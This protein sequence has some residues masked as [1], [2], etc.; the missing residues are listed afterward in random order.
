[1]TGH[2]IDPDREQFDYFKNL[3]RD[4]PIFMLNQVKFRAQACYP[5]DHQLA[6]SRISGAEAYR[7]Y[8]EESGPIFQRVGGSIFWRGRFEAVLTGPKD[9]SW[10]AV[11]I[12][13]YPNAHAFLEMVTDA[14]YRLAVV[15]RQAAVE[16]SR[17]IRL[18]ESGVGAGFAD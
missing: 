15:H 6:G 12:A 1:M 8:G 10:D 2:Y 4:T 14:N 7:L 17:L 11:F 9:E 5:E 13:R 18:A 3:N 16:T